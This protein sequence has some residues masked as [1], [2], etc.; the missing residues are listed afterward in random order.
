[1]GN[2]KHT[3]GP[4]VNGYGNGLTGPTTISKNPTVSG[5]ELD[6]VPISKNKETIG[7]VVQQ[8][9]KNGVEEMRANAALIASA[10]ELLEVLL[11]LAPYMLEAKLGGDVW[12]AIRDEEGAIEWVK[13]YKEAI[14]KATTIL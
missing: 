1:M 3:P 14:K 11:W 10:P 5:E 6:Y 8:D 7:C 13:K 4:W 12:C 9:N 2:F